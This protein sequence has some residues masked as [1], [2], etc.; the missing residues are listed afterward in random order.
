LRK[1]C[2]ER[3]CVS[4]YATTDR[5]RGESDIFERERRIRRRLRRRRLRGR[6]RRR[7]RSPPLMEVEVM[8][9]RLR[10]AKVMQ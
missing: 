5:A 1:S 3:Q 8:E 4:S 10:L 6:R 9:V 7:R 2:R